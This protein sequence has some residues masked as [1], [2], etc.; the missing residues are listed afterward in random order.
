MRREQENKNTV[1]P[2]F[3]R[4]FRSPEKLGIP[5]LIPISRLSIFNEL[6]KES[7]KQFMRLGK[8]DVIVIGD[9]E[10][11]ARIEGLG[12]LSERLRSL[13][14]LS[15]SSSSDHSPDI[16]VQPPPDFLCEQD[17]LFIILSESAVVAFLGTMLPN[18]Q[19]KDEKDLNGGWTYHISC[20]KQ[21][22]MSLLPSMDLCVASERIN[23]E[24][25]IDI[26]S[27]I[28]ALQGELTT[29]GEALRKLE[30]NELAIVLDILK[31]ISGK[32]RAHDVLYVFVEKISKVVPS[33]RCSIVRVWGQEEVA[34]VLASHDDAQLYDMSISLN[35]YPEV[36]KVLATGDKVIINDVREDPLMLPCL[37]IL[38]KTGIRAILVIPIVLYDPEVGSLILRAVRKKEGFTPKEIS[39]F[40]IVTN[41]AANALERAQ[42][43]ESVQQ[44]NKALE[45][46]AVTDGLTELYNHRYFRER[47]EEEILRASR[48]K[49]PLSCALFD[50][51]DFKKCNDVYGHLFGD[52]V[53]K[54]IAR[55]IQQTI[56]RTD[57][58]ARYGGE[59]FIIIMPQTD[60]HGA[61]AQA[62]RIRKAIEDKSF[63]F[64]GKDVKITISGGI[65]EMT[66]DD[67][68]TVED[69]IRT[70]DIGLYE[71]K[72]TGKNRI[73]A[74]QLKQQNVEETQ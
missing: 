15:G 16:I 44:A 52:F 17:R 53:L 61:F 38:I 71:A 50:I 41:A 45:K 30:K 59:E 58:P 9:V 70:A 21:I 7:L 32:R 39:F 60:I 74:V 54:E 65:A 73:V 12:A 40:E 19:G 36:K 51:D 42:L 31:S 22:L 69:M 35:K 34:H 2:L 49:L 25:V 6:C 26:S 28:M 5:P 66:H 1:Q 57:I 13:I 27:R 10:T 43:F 11:L 20:V 56:R 68:L 33:D 24:N 55:R 48:Y 4:I 67:V 18:V 23:L 62:E 14:V 46:L 29:G 37:D 63:S 3:E 64:M 8:E 72:R 47:L